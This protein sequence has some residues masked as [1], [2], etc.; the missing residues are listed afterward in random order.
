MEPSQARAILLDQHRRLRARFADLLSSANRVITSHGTSHGEDSVFREQID[1]FHREFDAHNASEE[2]LLVPILLLDF[3]WGEPR[4]K[5][6][7]EEHSEEHAS[8]RL[9]MQGPVREV[10][11][12]IPDLLEEIE[13]HMMAE[14]RTFLSP[15]VLRDD[16]VNVEDGD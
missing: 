10:A 14:E 6:M 7:L 3:A 11:A 15:A 4:L 9:A 16:Q 8:F 1:A 5:R 12:G 2:T 13:A